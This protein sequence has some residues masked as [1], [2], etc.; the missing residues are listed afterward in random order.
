MQLNSK[1]QPQRCFVCD[2]EK[3]SLFCEKK[4]GFYYKCESCG[5]LVSSRAKEADERHDQDALHG[6]NAARN[7]N[8]RFSKEFS[9]RE[10]ADYKKELRSFRA[11]RKLNRLLDIGCGTGGFLF[12]ARNMKWQSIGTEITSA[13]IPAARQ[14][15]LEVYLGDVTELDLEHGSFDVIRMHSVIEHL[16]DPQGVLNMSYKLLR[17]GGLLLISTINTDSFTASFQNENW[18]YFGPLY[19]VH[20]F[21]TSN[22]SLLLKKMGFK[23]KHLQTKGVKTNHRKYVRIFSL[24]NVLKLPAKMLDKGHRM[25]LESEKSGHIIR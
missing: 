22:L 18:K 20:L 24:D 1:V 5:L 17:Q 7:F 16:K 21:N 6:E 11:Y 8:F 13:Y 23:V 9:V 19:H 4:E 10:Q 12:A 15:E 25:Y 3:F 14:K 2:Q